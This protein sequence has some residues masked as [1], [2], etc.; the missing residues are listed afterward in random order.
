MFGTCSVT[1][2][3]TD[4]CRASQSLYYDK[5]H[6]MP[7]KWKGNA[8]SSISQTYLTLE[9][10]VILNNLNR[11]NLLGMLWEIVPWKATWKET[12]VAASNSQSPAPGPGASIQL[13]PGEP[14][15]QYPELKSRPSSKLTSFEV[16]VE[17]WCYPCH[18]MLSI[19]ISLAP[20]DSPGNLALFPHHD[21]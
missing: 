12:S 13:G 16:V 7:P 10:F 18:C 14:C 11:S 5:V 1:S 20:R 8:A 15:A 6:L 17:L 2:N 3:S 9:P 19:G 21:T 4:F